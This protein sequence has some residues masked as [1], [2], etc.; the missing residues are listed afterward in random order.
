MPAEDVVIETR[1]LVEHFFRHESGRLV[2]LLTRSLG[3]RRLDLVEDVVQASLMQALEVWARQGI[4]ADPAAWLYR[5]ARNRAVDTLRRERTHARILP[6]VAE[7]HDFEEQALAEPTFVEEIGDEPLR[8]LFLCC[9][10]SVPI[11]SRI[12]LALRTVC[13]FSTAEIARGLLTTEAN[14]QKRIVRAKERLRDEP[15]SWESPGLAPLR[16][17]LD[18][19]NS[20]IYLL[21]NEGYSASEADEPIRRDLCDEARRLAR[22]LAEHPVGDDQSVFALLALISFHAARFDARISMAG[23]VVLLDEQDRTTWDWALIREAMAWM[24][25]SA[26]GETL[27]RYHVEAGI[28]WEH[29]R[30]RSFAETDWDQIIRLYATLERIAPSPIHVLNRAVAEAYRNGPHAGL[31][32]LATVP[33]DQIPSRYPGW[34]AVV[35]ELHFRAGDLDRAEQAWSEALA[36]THSRVDQDF[37]R[38]RLANCRTLLQADRAP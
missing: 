4:P 21:F 28:A 34:P 37:I 36:L 10:E 23:T 26:S 12:A 13:G 3:V 35:A 32:R 27:S 5:T 29:C 7:G 24:A 20:V 2:A 6:R 9:H 14:V 25:R 15:G 31:A 1:D 22:M 16:G 33:H 30:A 8:L 17:R 18:A 38:G 19:V 11:E